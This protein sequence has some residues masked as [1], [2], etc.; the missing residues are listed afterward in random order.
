MDLDRPV[1]RTTYKRGAGHTQLSAL[2]HARTDPPPRP[3]SMPS[4]SSQIDR[5]RSTPRCPPSQRRRAK[6][7]NQYR[8][9][10][11]PIGHHEVS[12]LNTSAAVAAYRLRGL[13]MPAETVSTHAHTMPLVCAQDVADAFGNSTTSFQY[14]ARQKPKPKPRKHK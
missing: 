1:P 9:A 3:R 2:Q 5:K 6:T 12:W 13:C 4:N 11:S 10:Q 7:P 14:P 8:R